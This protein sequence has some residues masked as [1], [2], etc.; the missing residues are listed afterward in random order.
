MTKNAVDAEKHDLQLEYGEV[1]DEISK[2]L[3]EADFMNI[4]T[5]ENDILDEYELELHEILKRIR[6][7]QSVDDV[8]FTIL[9]VYK[10]YFGS[11]SFGNIRSSDSVLGSD[12]IFA[13]YRHARE[14][15][16]KKYDQVAIRIWT[17]CQ[18]G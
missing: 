18:R 17:L 15:D 11:L 5:V 4:G 16:I 7:A 10:K 6:V 14:A 3:F 8:L 1:Y 2:L 13:E 12:S 9:I